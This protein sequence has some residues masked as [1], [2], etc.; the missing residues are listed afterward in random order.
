MTEEITIDG[1]TYTIRD[2]KVYN[3]EGKVAIRLCISADM[4]G[5]PAEDPYEVKDILKYFHYATP[6]HAWLTPGEKYAWEFYSDDYDRCGL[7]LKTRQ[8]Y[9]D[10]IDNMSEVA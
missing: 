1:S 4:G 9:L 3:S 7:M 2:G 5:Y 6:H 10:A 8:D